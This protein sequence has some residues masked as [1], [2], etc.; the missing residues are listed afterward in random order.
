[1]KSLVTRLL[2]ASVLASSL[3]AFAADVGITRLGDARFKPIHQGLTFEEVRSALGTPATA[4]HDARGETLWTYAFTDTWGYRSEF[5]V[6][7]KDGVVAQAYS[8]RTQ[9]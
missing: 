3:G 1:M 6:V 9:E 4:T 8:E 2:L 7:F 5:D